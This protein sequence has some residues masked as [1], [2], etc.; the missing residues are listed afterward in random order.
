M[1]RAG[2]AAPIARSLAPLRTWV[3]ERLRLAGSQLADQ[4]RRFVDYYAGAPDRPM[5]F[6]GRKGAISALDGVQILA[7]HLD[8]HTAIGP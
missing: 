5:P 2:I 1:A 4:V 7:R 6:A 8:Q 3:D